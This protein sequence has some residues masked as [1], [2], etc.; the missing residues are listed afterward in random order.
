M[1]WSVLFNGVVKGRRRQEEAWG[2]LSPHPVPMAQ[3]C[4]QMQHSSSA[5]QINTKP[6]QV[7][8]GYR[9]TLMTSESELQS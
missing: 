9:L 4:M 6:C 1:L 7:I 5:E 3:L 8:V 2:V